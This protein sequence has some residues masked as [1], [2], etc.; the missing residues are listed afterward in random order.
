MEF[1]AT[2]KFA[3]KK[4]KI[5]ILHLSEVLNKVQ[6]FLWGILVESRKSV[7]FRRTEKAI[8]EGVFMGEIDPFLLEK[9]KSKLLIETDEE[10]ER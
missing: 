2:G 9:K 10:V 7:C 1:K 6:D 5:C 8:A 4:T 3:I